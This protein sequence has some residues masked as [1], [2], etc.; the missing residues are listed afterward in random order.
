MPFPLF[1]ASQSPRRRELLRQIGLDFDVLDV[2]V[3]ERREPGET[4]ADYVSRVAREK[5]GAGLLQV[6]AVPGAIVIG[7]DTEV[8]LDDD[9]F[10]KPADA[11]DALAML[12]RLTGRAHNVLSA[13]WCISASREEHALSV[14]TVEFATLSDVDLAAYVATGEAFGK[15]GAYAIQG[16]A[17]AFISRLEGSHSAVMGLPLHETSLLLKRLG[18][19]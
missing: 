4:P 5:A 6:A 18:V 2:D 12:R 13:V 1:L 3:P 11:A 7:A 10:G 15:A 16:R 19:T 14:S 8:V 17:A 9:V